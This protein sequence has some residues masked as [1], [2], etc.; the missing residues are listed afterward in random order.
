MTVLIVITVLGRNFAIHFS[1]H[2]A[3]SPLPDFR[4]ERYLENFAV[5]H[6]SD[7]QLKGQDS[8]LE[9][10]IAP[11]RTTG[12]SSESDAAQN[13]TILFVHV[14][15]AGGET[16][17]NILETGCRSRKNKRRRKQCLDK[18]PQS[19]LSSTVQGYFHCFTV[20]PA[21]YAKLA[22]SYLFNLRHPVDRAVSW[23]RY[24]HPENC[25]K[26]I[27]DPL[28]PVCIANR[29][30]QKEPDGWISKFFRRCFPTA[31]DWATVGTT[32]QPNP[33]QSQSDSTSSTS[34]NC[35]KLATESF[36]GGL[37]PRTVPLAAHMIANIKHYA[38]KTI[39]RFP[40]K[41]ILVV[42]TH[43]L[44]E[45]I[46]ELDIWLG[47]SGDFGG[48]EGSAVTH[49]SEHHRDSHKNEYLSEAASQQLCCSLL[50]DMTVYRELIQ[51][52]ANLNEAA[53]TAELAYLVS[54]C[55]ARSWSELTE[56]CSNRHLT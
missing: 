43:R 1:R 18:V 38:D 35:T 44:W 15:K 14:G 20:E 33:V 9:S 54:R 50:Q 47:G 55:S 22:S 45:D 34:A 30:L 39:R 48:A 28:S 8:P 24:V 10:V 7:S 13:R 5:S 53:K 56:S 4:V 16:I 25:K 40:D 32:P 46:Q 17:K 42:R 49:G 11:N 19:K 37:N 23:Y 3:S 12:S 2:E 27:S 31:E 6:A 52:A 21:R 41:E 36:S 26:G 29:Q 51:T